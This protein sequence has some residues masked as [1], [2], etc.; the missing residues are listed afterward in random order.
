MPKKYKIQLTPT[1]YSQLDEIKQ[2][3]SIILAAPEAAKRLLNSI[4]NAVNSLDI[5]PARVPL[6]DEDPWRS[7]GIH[8]MT[9]KNYL[10]YFWIDEDAFTV[11]VIAIVYGRREQATQLSKIDMK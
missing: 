6:A 5:M 7:H 10:V 11:H 8:K 3:I 1:V 4:R 9:V 2:Y